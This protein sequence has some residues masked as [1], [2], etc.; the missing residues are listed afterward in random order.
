[1]EI[2]PYNS[3]DLDSVISLWRTVFPDAPT[4]NDPFSDIQSKLR[5]Q[6]DLFFV[7]TEDGKLVGTAMSG[8]D[9]HRG[10]VYYVAVHPD[11]RRRGIG[12]A[13]M[14]R[15]EEALFE[16]GCPKLN[17]QIRADNVQVQSFYESLGYLVEERISMGKR[18]G[19]D[20]REH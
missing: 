15:V 11:D 2:R 19:E 6:P 1:M 13:L 17:L 10:W 9:G 3:N 5:I 4:H 12:S 18:L 8:F 16:I 7:A 20:Q 14:K